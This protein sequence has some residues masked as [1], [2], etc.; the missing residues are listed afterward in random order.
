MQTNVQG[1]SPADHERKHVVHKELTDNPRPLSC[2]VFL[3]VP[4]K[5]KKVVFSCFWF[6]LFQGILLNFL[7]TTL[8][9]F[10]SYPYPPGSLTFHKSKT[11]TT[12]PFRSD[13]KLFLNYFLSSLGTSVNPL[14]KVRLPASV[15][16]YPHQ[17]RHT[18]GG[19]I[20]WGP[21]EIIRLIIPKVTNLHRGQ[22]PLGV[23]TTKKP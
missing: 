6:Y 14:L 10:K 17:P 19:H 4:S 12:R 13:F 21:W 15:V 9:L 20:V 2:H 1:T 5:K 8:L 11:Y 18:Y 3:S 22:E 7:F 16:T 23:E